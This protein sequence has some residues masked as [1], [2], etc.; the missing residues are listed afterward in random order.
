MMYRIAELQDLFVDAVIVD[1]DN[2]L[3]FCS[4]FGRDTAIQQLLASFTLPPNAGGLNMIT[5]TDAPLGSHRHALSDE[6]SFV[7][8]VDEP[9]RLDKFSGRLPRENVFGN[10]SHTWIFDPVCMK[11]DRVNRKAWLFTQ[12]GEGVEEAFETRWKIWEAVKLLSALPLLDEWMELILRQSS[13][14]E[15]K[16]A[17]S[18]GR[19][20]ATTVALTEDY[21]AQIASMVAA[22]E[23]QL[24]APGPTDV[25]TQRFAVGTA[26]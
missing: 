20:F 9:A 4:I 14:C 22:R 6:N 21:E 1:D 5:M 19:L 26:A 11:P 12:V 7:A 16:T 8:Y 17:R 15:I 18:I 24:I 2:R 10:L 13:V 23:L 3:M 25:S